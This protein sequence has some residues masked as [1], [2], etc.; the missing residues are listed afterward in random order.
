V[1]A[2]L[3]LAY[4]R[5]QLEARVKK[6][7]VVGG[8]LRYRYVAVREVVHDLDHEAAESNPRVI[9][10]DPIDDESARRLARGG[11]RRGRR[12]VELARGVEM[13]VDLESPDCLVGAR[14]KLPASLLVLWH[15]E[16]E[17]L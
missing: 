2:Q 12:R 4:R 15:V 1:G 16:A 14:A 11:Q 6:S 17:V 7:G 13:A 10:D 9:R 5:R 3:A 8:R